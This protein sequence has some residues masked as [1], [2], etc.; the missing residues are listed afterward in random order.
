MS[1]LISRKAV[2][3]II[4]KEIDF[5]TEYDAD[6]ALI[7]LKDVIAE[8]PTAYSVEKVVAELEEAKQ[9]NFKA[10]KKTTNTFD[11]IAYGNV[12]NAYG[13]AID[14]VRKGGVE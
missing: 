3:D 2:L 8:I 4:Q 12:V 6:Y 14:I 5:G 13:N 11:V 9:K 10:F 1:D 7:D